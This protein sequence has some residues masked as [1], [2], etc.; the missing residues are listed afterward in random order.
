LTIDVTVVDY[1][2]GN[3]FS[4]SRA[5]ERAGAAVSITDSPSGI[6]CARRLVLPG[7]GAFRNGMQGLRSRQI[8]EQ[9]RRY[10]ASGRPLLGI[11][12]GMQL[13]FEWGAEF[14]HHEG[15]GLLKGGV[16]AIPPTDVHGNPQKV[17]HIGW[18]E[19][20]FASGRNTWA[21]TP[22]GDLEPGTAV[23]FVHSFTAGPADAS[24]RLADCQY[25]GRMLSAAVARGAL[26]GCQFHPEKSGRAGLKILKSFLSLNQ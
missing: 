6:H 8:V 14:G 10:G 11:C 5:L 7:V 1:G 24:D 20:F 17:P 9:L 21:N 12:L 15:L 25:H 2:L 13:L 18:N 22:L 16:E 23:Y 26:F 3:L 19:L 4:V